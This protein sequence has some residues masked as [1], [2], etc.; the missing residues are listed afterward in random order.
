[1]RTRVRRA[2]AP[3]ALA[4]ALALAGPAL[5]ANVRAIAVDGA[6]L[7]EG[8]SEKSRK[9]FVA[10]RGMPVEV[11]SSLPAWTKVRDLAGDVLW[12][13]AGELGA[14]THVIAAVAL[15]LRRTPAVDAAAAHRVDRGVLLEFVG[16]GP[17]GWIRVRHDG[18]TGYVR[19]DEV[20]GE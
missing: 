15:A 12:V 19:D 1:M 6:I 10:P 8:P 2:R 13:R 11:V 3:A 17:A 20:W 7:F 14:R 16:S 5:G 18:E 9:A 4:L